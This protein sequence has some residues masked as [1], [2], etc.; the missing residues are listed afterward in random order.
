MPL[1]PN[2]LVPLALALLVSLFAGWLLGLLWGGARGRDSDVQGLLAR[3]R[4]EAERVIARL[5]RQLEEAE[6]RGKEQVEVFQM[7]P[8]L[9][10]Q[11]FAAT[12]RREVAPAALKL[13][14]Q[15]FHP[16]QCALFFARPSQKRL[17]LAVGHGLAPSV[18]AGL[19]L[20][21]GEGRVGYV[22]ETGLTMDE[23]DFRSSTPSVRRHLEATSIRQ[24]VADVVAPIEDEHG[25][26]GVLCM[27]GISNQHGEHKRLFRMVADLTGLAMSYVTRL[28]RTQQDAE[29]DGLTGAYNKR[30]L[31]KRLGDEVHRAER[32]SGSMSLFIMDIDHFKHYN[33]TNG[34]L[35][36]DEVLKKLGEILKGT[37]RQDDVVAR[38]G[39]E[40]F[41]VLYPGAAKETAIRLADKVR[42][43]VESCAFPHGARQPEGRLTISGGVATFPEDALNA[44][45]LIR[46]ADQALY[47]AKGAGRNRI[48][49]AVPN[50]LT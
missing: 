10:G 38:Y 9:V 26:V 2:T 37:L 3:E 27:G 45:E 20:A 19:E 42:R 33:D 50:F 13:V 22:A 6:A 23:A 25:L 32:Q 17:A 11:M 12:S 46:C 41:I 49:A 21:Y 40:E 24:V 39:G 36:G 31:Q 7:L 44:V 48:V 4:L 28:G 5:H 8:D 35:E 16:A 1:D 43:S 30:Y 34:H 15:I 18:A 14:D 29:I 47:E